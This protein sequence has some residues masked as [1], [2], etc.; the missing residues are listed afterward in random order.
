M[1]AAEQEDYNK[2]VSELAQQFPQLIV[3][4]DSLGNAVIDQKANWE[5]ILEL[6]KESIALSIS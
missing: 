5:K 4:Y 6:Q 2:V 1:T 3:G